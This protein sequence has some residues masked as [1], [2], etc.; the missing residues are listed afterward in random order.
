[1]NTNYL[2]IIWRHSDSTVLDVLYSCINVY[3]C[4][5][6][7]RLICDVG[8]GSSLDDTI[9]RMMGFILTDDVAKLYNLTGQSGKLGFMKLLVFE[10]ICGMYISLF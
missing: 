1:M 7:I 3:K 9:K 2:V 5:F 10:V 6:Q 4:L 8:S